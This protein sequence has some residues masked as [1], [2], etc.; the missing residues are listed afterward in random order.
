MTEA[1]LAQLGPWGIV[2]GLLYALLR[3][4][5]VPIIL[6][7][8]YL[9]G[10]RRDRRQAAGADLATIC[11]SVAANTTAT[12]ALGE[13][14][15]EHHRAVM[16]RVDNVVTHVSHIEGYLAGRNGAAYTPPRED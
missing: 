9:N 13:K 5:L 10:G 15:S 11:V 1:D 12:E 6:R 3:E 2:V 16:G 14:V 8:R 7:R 4:S